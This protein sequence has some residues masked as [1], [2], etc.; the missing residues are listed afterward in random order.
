MHAAH[1]IFASRPT[2]C[3]LPE[4]F[5][6]LDELDPA[7]R[8]F[9]LGPVYQQFFRSSSVKIAPGTTEDEAQTIVFNRFHQQIM[10]LAAT[11]PPAFL[12]KGIVTTTLVWLHGSSDEAYLNDFLESNHRDMNAHR[13]RFAR[14][15]ISQQ[16][17]DHLL[18]EIEERVNNLRSDMGLR[19]ALYERFCDKVVARIVQ[20]R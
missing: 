18:G 2:F 3:G 15:A 8:H 11:V 5:A 12:A 14:G 20:M 19:R 6:L 10:A 7:D 13:E 9:I 17:L 16:Q 4:L 1:Q